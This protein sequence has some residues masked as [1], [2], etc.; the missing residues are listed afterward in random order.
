MLE[1]QKIAVIEGDLSDQ[2]ARG[3]APH[4]PGIGEGELAF[5]FLLIVDCGAVEFFLE[6]FQHLLIKIMGLFK[7]REGNQISLVTPPELLF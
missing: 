6:I 7:L 1:T 5:S 3:R 4:E 2:L